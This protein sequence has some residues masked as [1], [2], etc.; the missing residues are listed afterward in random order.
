[1]RGRKPVPTAMRVLRGNPG[2]RAL[3]TD[4]PQAA[5]FLPDPP[6]DLIGEGLAEWR[7]VGP[8][9]LQLG[10]ITALDAP[11]FIAYCR[12]W[13]RYVGAEQKVTEKG[14]I[15]VAPSGFPIQNPYLAIANRAL[16]ECRA[17]WADFGM[18]PSARTRV[19]ASKGST[20]S[21][22]DRFIRRV[23]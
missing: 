19:K 21:K 9:L 23:K 18:T 7:R 6:A 8:H 17:F 3:P 2:K 12:N 4:E 16:A 14:L 11:A 13:H 22:L 5:A 20:L 15:V 1:M 10:L